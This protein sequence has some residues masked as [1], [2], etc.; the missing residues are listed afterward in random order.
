MNADEPMR[1]PE[2]SGRRTHARLAGALL[3]GVV[4][5]ACAGENA[6]T[7][8]VQAISLL[9]PQVEITAPI[10]PVTVAPGDS[11]EVTASLTS[12]EGMTEVA[13]TG[14]LD[15][16]G[17]A[18][19][20]PIVVPLAGVLDTTM[21]RFVKRVVGSPAGQAKIIVTATDVTGDTGA[22]TI[23]VTLGS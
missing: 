6:F 22:D 15:A 14:T 10:P 5:A 17:A 21:S 12:G 4:V 7:F 13:W 23:S 19:F 16:G 11:V 3:A 1:R 8:A 20:I 9:G 18:P 2:E